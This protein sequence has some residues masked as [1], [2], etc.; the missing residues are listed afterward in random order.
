MKMVE[1]RQFDTVYREHFSYFG[2][3]TACA[4]FAA[5]GLRVYDVERLPT[6]GG[7]LRLGVGHRRQQA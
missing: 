1:Q 4:V 5:H 3:H 2:L 7:S 6:H